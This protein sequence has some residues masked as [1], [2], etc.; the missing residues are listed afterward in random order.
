MKT[1]KLLFFIVL[2]V[3]FA[4]CGSSSSLTRGEQYSKFYEEKPLVILVMPPINNTTCVDAK[5]FLY[6][7]I[8]RPL[9]EMGYYVVSP[10][11]AMDIFK[12]ESAYDA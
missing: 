4:S 9:V 10:H 7:S 2:C 12:A 11:L 6:T 5:E 3:T 8:S 1:A